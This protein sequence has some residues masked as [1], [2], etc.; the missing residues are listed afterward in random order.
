MAYGITG[1]LFTVFF[2]WGLWEWSKRIQRKKAAEND[3]PKADKA[4]SN[5][6]L[7]LYIIIAIAII[8]LV[9]TFVLISTY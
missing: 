5:V 9:V 7:I 2:L 8:A 3:R 4:P 1:G 6:K